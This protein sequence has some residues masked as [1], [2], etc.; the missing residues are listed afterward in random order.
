MSENQPSAMHPDESASHGGAWAL[1]WDIRL[2]A[3]Y[4]LKRERFLDG[5]DRA[6]KAISA[7]SGAAAFAQIRTDPVLGMWLTAG[8]AVVAT[9]SLV[10][11]PATK[12]RRHAELARDMKRLEAEIVRAGAALE[13]AE[14]ARLRGKFHEIE[15]GEPA[16]LGALVTQ[17]HNELASGIGQRASITPLPWHQRLL[18]NWFD[19]DQSGPPGKG[20]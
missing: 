14:L 9:L 15:S 17:C 6:A 16:A 10:Y 19:F 1:L 11:S 20:A 13:A 4:H 8:I 18:K 5:V 2:S 3:L 12:A 7:L